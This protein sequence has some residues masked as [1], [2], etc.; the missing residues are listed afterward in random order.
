MMFNREHGHGHYPLN[1][2]AK[3]GSTGHQNE[4]PLSLSDLWGGTGFVTGV[5]AV[6]KM[7]LQPV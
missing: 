7:L 1:S 3:S 5:I 2:G 4:A 6:S